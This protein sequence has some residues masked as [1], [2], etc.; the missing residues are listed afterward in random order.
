[1]RQPDGEE[2]TM[3][4]IEQHAGEQ[5]PGESAFSPVARPVVYQEGDEPEEAYRKGDKA[6]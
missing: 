4:E 5:K 6:E 1:M 3:A 2:E